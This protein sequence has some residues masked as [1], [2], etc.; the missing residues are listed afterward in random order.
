MDRLAAYDIVKAREALVAVRAGRAARHAD[1]VAA[2][3]RGRTRGMR[4]ILALLSVRPG[5]ASCCAA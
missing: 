5:G 2:W 4:G 3:R 1:G